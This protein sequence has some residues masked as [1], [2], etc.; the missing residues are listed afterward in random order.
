MM[1][2]SARFAYVSVA[3][4]EDGERGSGRCCCF[5][6]VWMRSSSALMCGFHQRRGGPQY[7]DRGSLGEYEFWWR[8]QR[9]FWR[10]VRIMDVK[11]LLIS[12]LLGV[13]RAWS[14]GS[15]HWYADFLATD[16]VVC[17]LLID[18]LSLLRLLSSH[19][20]PVTLLTSFLSFCLSVCVCPVWFYSRSLVGSWS[21]VFSPPEF[22]QT[23]CLNSFHVVVIKWQY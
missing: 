4:H 13:Y 12:L 10:S 8:T 14:V 16:T 22:A 18:Y 20:M 11:R 7:G 9:C 15:S 6:C 21:V 2:R 17:L 5:G 23:K 1:A 3:G 19:Y